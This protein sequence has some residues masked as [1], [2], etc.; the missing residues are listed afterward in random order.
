MK[1]DVERLHFGSY[2]QIVTHFNFLLVFNIN[3]PSFNK[4]QQTSLFVFP[5]FI[6]SFRAQHRHFKFSIL[7]IHITLQLL[8]ANKC[9]CQASLPPVLAGGRP[10]HHFAIESLC[11]NQGRFWKENMLKLNL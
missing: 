3:R 6:Q 11:D 2:E 1:L 7:K 5:C 8:K 4:A 9:S 10:L